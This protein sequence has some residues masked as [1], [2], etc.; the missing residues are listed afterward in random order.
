MTLAGCSNSSTND[1]GTTP[2]TPV[3]VSL[4]APSAQQQS[5]QIPQASGPVTGTINVPPVTVAGGGTG[6]LTLSVLSG[7]NVAFEEAEPTHRR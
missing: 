5:V 6:N 1:A 4:V 2:T 3:S 7:T